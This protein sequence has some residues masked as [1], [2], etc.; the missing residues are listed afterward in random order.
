MS[1]YQELDV[2]IGQISIE[3]QNARRYSIGLVLLILMF[4][5]TTSDLERTQKILLFLYDDLIKHPLQNNDEANGENSNNLNKQSFF[6]FLDS[7]HILRVKLL[8]QRFLNLV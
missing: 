5:K 3:L 7:F 8:E 1:N 2:K 4:Y 6:I